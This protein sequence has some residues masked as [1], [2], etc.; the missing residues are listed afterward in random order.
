M[1]GWVGYLRCLR[2]VLASGLLACTCQLAQAEG[3]TQPLLSFRRD[4]A[5]TLPSVAPQPVRVVAAGVVAAGLEAD[6]VVPA[7]NPRLLPPPSQS[8]AAQATPG[9]R[10]RTAAFALPKIE[11]LTTA[12]AGLGIVVGLFLICMWLLRKT[13]PK[14]T[15]HLPREAVAVLGR[16]PLAARNFAQLLQV[17]NKLVLVSVTPDGVVPITEVTDPAEVDRLL[18][19][20]LRNHKQSTTAEFHHVLE[21]LAQEPANGFLGNEATTAYTQQKR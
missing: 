21:K 7:Q 5:A 12:A 1:I 14:P 13:G 16:V 8:S 10:R 20:C 18:G 3:E 6:V 11:S 19:M 15:S 2:A 17:G 4:S 9:P